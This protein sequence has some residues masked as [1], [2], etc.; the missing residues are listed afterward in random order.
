MMTVFTGLP[1]LALVGFGVDKLQINRW[2]WLILWILFSA[3][4]FLF[5]INQYPTIEKALSKNG[6]WTAYIACS[7]NI[8]LYSSTVFSVITHLVSL[9]IKK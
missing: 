5:G 2:L 9:K 6:S 8:A 3:V 4:I 1:L 7:L